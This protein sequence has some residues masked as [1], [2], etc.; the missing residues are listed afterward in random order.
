MPYFRKKRIETTTMSK[1]LISV[2]VVLL[3]G[4]AAAFF[5]PAVPHQV[6]DYVAP[7]NAE[8]FGLDN[9]GKLAGCRFFCASEDDLQK[10]DSKLLL[11]QQPLRPTTPFLLPASVASAW[12]E[13]GRQTAYVPL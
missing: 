3:I 1:G 10:T 2:V 13:P 8:L 11:P 9:P 6:D 5:Q 7:M 4:V 12:D